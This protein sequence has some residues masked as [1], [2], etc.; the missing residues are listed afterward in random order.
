MAGRAERGANRDLT[1]RALASAIMAFMSA[2]GVFGLAVMIEGVEATRQIGWKS[3][4]FTS[5]TPVWKV[6]WIESCTAN[7]V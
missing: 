7:I 2:H 4:E 3:V 5:A 6:E 1:G